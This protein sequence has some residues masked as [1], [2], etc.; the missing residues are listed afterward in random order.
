MTNVR[1][2]LKSLILLASIFSLASV[3]NAQATRTWVSGVGDDVNPCSRTA[4]CKT[5][6]GA[7]SKTATNGE[8]NALDPGGFGT[9]TITKSITVNGAETNASV[10]NA[11]LNGFTVAYDS[12]GAD[13]RKSVR[14]RNVSFQGADTGTGGIRIIG[15][16][17]AGS[18]VLVENVIIDGNNAGNGRGISD[19]RSGGGKLFVHNVTI[20]NCS[21]TGIAIVPASGAT[22]IDATIYNV[23]VFN[24]NF[25]GA[26]G[27]GSV[28]SV[29]NS[30]F[31]N[32][33]TGLESEGINGAAQMN[34][35][36]SVITGNTVNGIQNGGGAFGA[37]IRIGDN[38]ISF[39]ATGISGQTFSFGTNRISGNTSAGTA[40]TAMGGATS[41][42]GQQ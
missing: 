8:I 41:A 5:W 42:L 12:F 13:V 6:A 9:L 23:R 36:R 16:A 35:T 25:G 37:T 15:A 4:P 38:D 32:N 7:I 26:F 40:P 33:G 28:V 22:R 30:V 19:E 17:S 2:T 31:A 14:I 24:C 1:F 29:A 27:S 11:G 34:V 39:N 10:L 20:S 18:E 21:G 3:A